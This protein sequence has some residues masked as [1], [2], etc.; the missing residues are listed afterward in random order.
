MP[1]EW[2]RARRQMGDLQFGGVFRR[3]RQI[4]LGGT[5]V[6]QFFLIIVHGIPLLV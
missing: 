6:Q 3:L 1:R 4:A 2:R 5:Q